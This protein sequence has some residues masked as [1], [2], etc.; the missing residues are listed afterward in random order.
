MDMYKLLKFKFNK[1]KIF[2]EILYMWH[3]A[4]KLIVW[5]HDS[6]MNESYRNLWLDMEYRV[7]KEMKI[8]MF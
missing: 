2:Y 4:M 6:F 1:L 5:C 8:W 7:S 3:D